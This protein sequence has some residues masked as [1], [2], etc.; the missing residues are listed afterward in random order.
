MDFLNKWR[1]STPTPGER[2]V[3]PGPQPAVNLEP[4]ADPVLANLAELALSKPPQQPSEPPSSTYAWS[5]R[6]PT[7]LPPSPIPGGSHPPPSTRSPPLLPRLGHSACASASGDIYIFGGYTG[8]SYSNDLFLYSQR[9]NTATLLQCYGDIP[10]SRYRHVSAVIGNVFL[11]WGGTAGGGYIDGLYLLNLVRRARPAWELIEPSSFEVPS[12]RDS[13]ISTLTTQS[14]ED[15]ACT[16]TLPT[17]RYHHAIAIVDDVLYVFSGIYADG[18][19]EAQSDEFFAFKISTRQWFSLTSIGSV[20]SPRTSH[21]MTSVGNRIFVI[22][23]SLKNRGAGDAELVFYALDFKDL[24]ETESHEGVQKHLK[25]LEEELEAVKLQRQMERQALE[26]KLLKVETELENLYQTTLISKL[27]PLLRKTSRLRD[28]DEAQILVDLLSKALENDVVIQ[29]STQR[30]HLLHLLA[31]IA[32][33]SQVF[34]KRFEITGVQCD[35][36]ATPVNEGGY[37]YIFKGAYENQVVCVKAVKIYGSGVRDKALRAHAGELVLAANAT[38]PNIVP[39]YGAYVS[40]EEP[41][42]ICIVTPWME[43]GNLLNF[44]YKFPDTSRIHLVYDVV[45]GLQHLHS[46]DIVHSD[47]KASNVLVSNSKRAMVADFGVSTIATTS[48]GTTTARDIAGTLNWMAPELVVGS[49]ALDTADDTDDGVRPPT[50]ES[51][52]W[53]LGCLCFEV[54]GVFRIKYTFNRGLIKLKVLTG[55]APFEQFRKS[56]HFILAF[57]RGGAT[58]IQPNPKASP[59]VIPGWEEGPLTKAA[60]L[61]WDYD[62]KLRPS[63]EEIL[64]DL[65]KEM[66]E[67]TRPSRDAEDVMFEAAKRGRVVED[68]MDYQRVSAI[69]KRKETKARPHTPGLHETLLEGKKDERFY[70]RLLSAI[71]SNPLMQSLDAPIRKLFKQ[72]LVVLNS[73]RPR[74][75][76]PLSTMH[77]AAFQYALGSI[78]VVFQVPHSSTIAGTIAKEINEKCQNIGS[79][80]PRTVG[81]KSLELARVVHEDTHGVVGT[82]LQDR[83]IE[84][85]R[86]LKKTREQVHKWTARDPIAQ[87]LSRSEMEKD[88]DYC[89]QELDNVIKSY[90]ASASNGITRGTREN[91][92]PHEAKSRSDPN[93]EKQFPNPMKR[94][95]LQRPR[96]AGPTL[97]PK[98]A[99]PRAVPSV[100]SEPPSTVSALDNRTI[101]S[102]LQQPD[103]SAIAE[104][105]ETTASSDVREPANSGAKPSSNPPHD[106]GDS[107]S[108]DPRE[109]IQKILQSKTR[110]KALLCSTGDRAQMALDVL[111][112]VLDSPGEQED[113]RRSTLYAIMRLSRSS[114]AYPTCLTLK[115]VQFTGDHPVTSGHF[116]DIWRGKLGDKAVSMKAARLNE[117]SQIDHLLKN[118]YREAI[119]WSYLEHP[120]LLPFYGVYHM[121][122]HF[123][124]V[125]LVSPWMENGNVKEYLDAFPDK[126]RFRLVMDILA[127]LQYLHR[128]KLVHG[129]LKSPNILISQNGSACLADFGLS[130]IVDEHILR[131]TT[132]TTVSQTGGT[133]RWEAPELLDDSQQ[134][135]PA[136][137]P[138][139]ASDV[140]SVACVMYE[141]ITGNIPFH[142]ASR[143]ATVLFMKFK[144][145]TPSKPSPEV[146]LELT[147]EIWK[148]MEN[149]WDPDPNKRPSA[150]N[151]AEA[152]QQ[153]SPSSLTQKRVALQNSS[154][155]KRDLSPERLT[156]DAFRSAI[157]D[158]EV[159]FTAEEI[160]LLVELNREEPLLV[161]GPDDTTEFGE[162]DQ[163]QVSIAKVF[164]R[165]QA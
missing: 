82:V 128:Q 157:R 53:S 155:K 142:E 101:S 18:H 87:F 152:L 72:P 104:Q 98:E 26:N 102:T 23:G 59:L 137:R 164:E 54:S 159:H 66:G 1:A 107:K 76:S 94:E 140:Y 13:T 97:T 30:K 43:A 9:E 115:K 21:M 121:G 68:K 147:P 100:T 69:V 85:Y 41:P 122:D 135:Q 78:P 163:M 154:G 57:S 20:P 67:D 8:R 148:I 124:R 11:L 136:L 151:I 150:S 5:S 15:S 38:H 138:T 51:D 113:S 33:S 133:L 36:T 25:G 126:P 60:A 146:E 45:S 39:F 40:Q 32:K 22:G 81:Q 52:M 64:Q 35:V 27:T 50:K 119:M 4:S 16:G 62:P 139:M 141:L 56:N 24:K 145:K 109:L 70:K 2:S 46:L 83:V 161:D 130:S 96:G 71:R 42:R 111:Q 37:G 3:I 49:D 110:Y 160:D 103:P 73:L 99:R 89:A 47:L 114:G 86:V 10:S 48:V 93:R 162:D 55:R 156:V 88:M 77:N 34:P 149:C 92:T 158:R 131:W 74:F 63:T 153:V 7:L 134:G 84:A 44:L 117:P 108:K 80:K 91:K 144:G 143:D 79:G 65:E 6:R 120:N 118:F 28:S 132:L 112:K 12:P 90:K 123:N 31:K 75:P 125:C 129:D 58:P 19:P 105:S 17:G 95:V 127:G 61:C 106:H 29:S 116:G 14:T 165:S